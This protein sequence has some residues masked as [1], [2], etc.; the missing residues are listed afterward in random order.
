MGG[1]LDIE[2]HDDIAAGGE[3]REDLGFESAVVVAV[4]EGVFEEFTGVDAAGEFVRGEEK[5]VVAVGFARADGAG[6]AGDGVGDGFD[7]GGVSAERGFA[8][9]GGAGDDAE[10][11]FAEGDGSHGNGRGRW[12]VGFARMSGRSGG[13]FAE[14]ATAAE[15]AGDVDRVVGGGR[16]HEA[17]GGG[18]AAAFEAPCFF[19]EVAGVGVAGFVEGEEPELEGVVSGLEDVAEH[20]DF[21]AAAG[22]VF[23]LA[24]GHHV[25]AVGAGDFHGVRGRGVRRR[26]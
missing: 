14:T 15:P 12:G 19:C 5:V 6:G 7:G 25:T 1:A 18:F 8:A 2:V 3:V 11:A 13:S 4:D 22:A 24:E 16:A 21:A 10:D 23:V 20:G 17:D 9:A 26:R